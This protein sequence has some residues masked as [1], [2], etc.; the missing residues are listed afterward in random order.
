[1]FHILT[2]TSVFLSL[3]NGCLCQVIGD[4]IVH[5]KPP[6]ILSRRFE[7]SNQVEV[8]SQTRRRGTKRRCLSGYVEERPRKRAKYSHGAENTKGSSGGGAERFFCPS[9]RLRRVV[10]IGNRIT[11]ADVAFLRARM[12]YS[13]P[14]FVPH[15]T[16][17]I[18]GLPPKRWYMRHISLH[19]THVHDRRLYRHPQPHISLLAN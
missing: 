16:K 9:Q 3:P 6:I 8:A 15:T 10:D 11:P 17:I 2:E 1:M 5:L 13:R 12:F 7:E 19:L 14:S 18:V 4:P